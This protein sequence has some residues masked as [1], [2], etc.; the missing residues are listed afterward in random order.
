[1]DCVKMDFE[2]EVEIVVKEVVKDLKMVVELIAE[3]GPSVAADL[4]N[5][6]MLAMEVDPVVGA[7]L[8][9]AAKAVGSISDIAGVLSK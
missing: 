7:E 4:R 8:N 5:L 1:M 9:T 6:S 2:E 3:D